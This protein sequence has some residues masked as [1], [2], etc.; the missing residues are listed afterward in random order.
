[1]TII[2]LTIGL[3][4]TGKKTGFGKPVTGSEKIN[5]FNIPM[6]NRLN[7]STLDAKN[8]HVGAINNGSIERNEFLTDTTALP[9]TLF[10]LTSDYKPHSILGV[11]Y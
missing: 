2:P 3:S 6:Q 1:M 8:K 7:T 5:G 9:S 4:V 10:Y 11:Y